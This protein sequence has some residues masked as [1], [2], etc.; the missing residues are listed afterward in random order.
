[1]ANKQWGDL[2]PTQKRLVY[3]AGAAEAV[4][5]AAALRDLTRRPSA[6]VRGPKA[7]W[8]LAFFVQPVGPLAYLLVGRR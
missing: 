7:G 1:M 3:V 5:T 4:V 6:R 8:V 2:S